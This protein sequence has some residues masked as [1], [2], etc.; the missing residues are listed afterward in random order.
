MVRVQSVTR[1]TIVGCPCDRWLVGVVLF[2]LTFDSSPIK[3]EGD[4]VVLTCSPV[5]PRA[6][7]P[8]GLRIKSAM[9][10]PGVLVVLACSLA[11]HTVILDLIQNPQGGV[12]FPRRKSASK[13]CVDI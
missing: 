12:R 2:T 13:W 7:C 5:L 4:M 9:T 3:G 8:S 10:V 1:A 11:S 6:P